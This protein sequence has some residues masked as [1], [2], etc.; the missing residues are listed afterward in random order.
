VAVL[1]IK[2]EKMKHLFFIIFLFS[3]LLTRNETGFLSLVSLL[4]FAQLPQKENKFF[5]LFYLAFFFICILLIHLGKGF[6]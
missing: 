5:H 3:L 4:C 1:L 6:F 2:N